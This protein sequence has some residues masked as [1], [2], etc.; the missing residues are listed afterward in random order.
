[1]PIS[2]VWTRWL[3]GGSSLLPYPW[4]NQ[5]IFLAERIG[6]QHDRK[7]KMAN[8]LNLVGVQ[9][10]NIAAI[11]FNKS[12]HQLDMRLNRENPIQLFDVIA[13]GVN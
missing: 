9:T 3:L 6:F 10:G 7:F 8:P 12:S 11:S 2:L 4:S 5:E 1:M 13:H